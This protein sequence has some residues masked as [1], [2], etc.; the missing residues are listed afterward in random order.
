[1]ESRISQQLIA[2][3]LAAIRL[4]SSPQN[5]NRVYRYKTPSEIR[6]WKKSFEG[7][8]EKVDRNGFRESLIYNGATSEVAEKHKDM[9]YGQVIDIDAS[10]DDYVRIATTGFPAYVGIWIEVGA[11]ERKAEQVETLSNAKKQMIVKSWW[12]VDAQAF[13]T[14]LLYPELGLIALQCRYLVPVANSISEKAGSAKKEDVSTLSPNR[15][16]TTCSFELK[17]II[18]LSKLKDKKKAACYSETTLRRVDS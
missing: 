5:K 7:V 13:F 3:Q 9:P 16:K 17:L 2:E 10:D 15:S 8:W 6:K 11:S 14:E 4:R 1:M 12:D 18:Q